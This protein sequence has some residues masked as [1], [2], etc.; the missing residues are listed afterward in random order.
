M[1]AIPGSQGW[2]FLLMR[3]YAPS[4]DLV[5]PAYAASTSHRVT[6]TKRPLLDSVSSNYPVDCGTNGDRLPKLGAAAAADTRLHIKAGAK[7]AADEMVAR[8]DALERAARR[9]Q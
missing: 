3:L 1:P 8:A 7:R 2:S 6:S 4:G 5:R 9:R